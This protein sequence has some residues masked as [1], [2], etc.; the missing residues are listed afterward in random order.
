MGR[1]ATER[2]ILSMLHS[3]SES[4]VGRTTLMKGLMLRTGAGCGW[5]GLLAAAAWHVGLQGGAGQGGLRESP[6]SW[7]WI[8]RDNKGSGG[9]VS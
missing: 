7:R 3:M 8:G 9:S 5:C 4:A 6:L 2:Q 1:T